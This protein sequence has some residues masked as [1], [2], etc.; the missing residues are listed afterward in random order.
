L[1]LCYGFEVLGLHRIDLGVYAFNPRAQH[2][3]EK[4]GFL[5][6]GIKRDAYRFDG[7]YVDEVWMS[8]LSR[9]WSQHRGRPDFP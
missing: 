5:V 4:V 7:V 3:Y 6:E 2:V 9:E 8:I 1:I